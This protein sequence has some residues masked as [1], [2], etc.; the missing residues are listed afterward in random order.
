[1][2]LNHTHNNYIELDRRFKKIDPTKGSEEAALD[3]YTAGFLGHEKT[4][5]WK[6]LLEQ[7]L[8][9]VV[10]EAGSGKTREFQTQT[11]KLNSQGIPAFF[12]PLDR[13]VDES[14]ESILDGQ[15][16]KQFKKWNQGNLEAVFFLDSVDEAK[17]HKITDFL[18][19]LDRFRKS[20]SYRNLQRLK[21]IVSSR[22][23][24]WRPQTDAYELT[25]RFLIHPQS[26]KDSTNSKKSL[27]VVQL[28]PL[29]HTR[30]ELF[31]REYGIANPEVFIQS[32]ED[33]Y[34]WDL[35]RRPMDVVGI[36][37]Y[38]RNHGCFGSLTDIIEFDLSLKLRETDARAKQDPLT[39]QKVREGA[40]TL[41]AAV[42]FCR[43]FNFKV[44]DDAYAT[45]GAA[46]DVAEC[47]PDGW[48]SKE[49]LALLARPIFDSAS[50]G[51]IRFHNRRIQEYLAAQWLTDRMDKGCSITVLEDVLFK[52]IG[53]G[54]VI[55]PALAPITAWL[56][57]G[58]ETWN[59]RVRSWILDAAPWLHSQYADPTFLPL[60]YKRQLL[61]SLIT[62]YEGRQRV[63]VASEP[64]ALR[65]LADP[66]LSDDV[67]RIIRDKTVS[68][69]LRE[70]MLL[71]VR[72]GRLISCR[73]TVLEIIDSPDEPD[74][75]KCYAAAA[76]LDIADQSCRQRLAE[77]VLRLP[78]ISSS[79][80]TIL[81]ETLYPKTIDAIALSSI[82][83]KLEKTHKDNFGL[84]SHFKH[85]LESELNP[86][87]CGDLLK[88][89]II[90]A[91]TPPHILQ[92]NKE[93][94]IS[95]RFCWTSTLILSI[96]I[97]LLS[98]SSLTIS[99][100]NIA[101]ESLLIL[102]YMGDYCDLDLNKNDMAHELDHATQKH[103]TVRQCYFWL[104][105]NKWHNKD[106][107][108]PSLIF[109]YH[110]I[111]KRKPEDLN[112]VIEDIKYR[113]NNTDKEIALRF[114][115]E[116]CNV[117]EK[118]AKNR[119]RVA[120]VV[121]ERHDL[122]KVFCQLAEGDV[123]FYLK[124]VWF[125][126][127]K[128]KLGNGWWWKGKLRKIRWNHGR[129][130]ERLM[131][132]W[133]INLLK[134]G[135]QTHWLAYLA[136]DASEDRS[137]HQWTPVSW[138]GL[139]KSSG[140]LITWGTK[141]G[142]K[143]AWRRFSPQLPH[144][145]SKP[146]EID[147]RIIAGLAGIK[148]ALDDG[149]ID[150]A[151]ISEADARLA[152]RYAVNELN[153]FAPWLTELAIHQ[154]EAVRN[155]L[156]EC[157]RGE[158]VSK[159]ECKWV[160]E[161]LSDLIWQGEGLFHLVK[162]DLIAQLLNGDPENKSILEHALTLLI[163]QTDP[164]III[165]KEIAS[166]RANIY[167]LDSQ[168]F[169]LWLTVWLQTDAKPALQFL[170]ET[171]IQ[172]ADVNADRLI[173][174]V[175]NMLSERTSGRKP[176]L[177]KPD[178]SKPDI[179]RIFI[180]LVYRH[181][182]KS[183]DINRVGGGVYSPNERDDAQDFR[184]SLLDLLVQSEDPQADRVLRELLDEPV[185]NHLKDWICHKLEERAERFSD[186][187]PWEPKDIR[188]FTLEY[189]IDPRT[190]HDLFKIA[191]RRIMDIKYA[192]EKS[193]NSLRNELRREDDESKLRSWI[194]RKLNEQSRKRYTVLQ[195]EEIDQRQR[196]DL[197]I[198]NPR[199]NPIS[200]EIKWADAQWSFSDL[201]ERLENQLIGQ[202]LRAHNSNY[203][204]Y[205]L[206][207]IGNKSYWLHPETNEH[208]SF[209]QILTILEERAKN[210]VSKRDDVNDIYVVGIDFTVP[211][212]KE[213][214]ARENQG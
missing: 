89:L 67:T 85:H 142:C 105:I 153:G 38:W 40:E 10:G 13:L 165:L 23:T 104:M 194:A 168:G 123:K 143:R 189:E 28:E 37:D 36:I 156:A 57:N 76:I 77:I 196:P 144:E 5:G 211:K 72:H 112:W 134:T 7:Q 201:L 129:L 78:Q 103:P 98:K 43:Q 131:L 207:N 202:Y 97:K 213:Q 125:R 170:E 34:L 214:R 51:R 182:R 118:R 130:K 26:N 108:R 107:S 140:R 174:R 133:N 121:A 88:Q 79:L 90:L 137:H 68:I 199:T 154:P 152:T 106:K 84:S 55:R 183:E 9:V 126:Y 119:R 46:I 66:G 175:C 74:D 52:Q 162:D 29:D 93:T 3:S 208:L 4:L 22:I 157:I 160:D 87:D 185:L 19:A 96:L 177:R 30:V 115:V 75:L 171:L 147:N 187:Q 35:A 69:D 161:V 159:R 1:M 122:K 188:L 95:S 179:L 15:E 2:K 11:K 20:F 200:I 62:R 193:D 100:T 203:G 172:R 64:E 192:V 102:G 166:E 70:E 190:D 24:E 191:C 132:I 63:W 6:E 33:N 135:K 56:A 176:L 186:L 128:F 149:E 195:E 114:A 50:Y 184:G 169:I 204:I 8:V 163:R 82:L 44:P 39:M 124:R 113:Q 73:D 25:K 151:T 53:E 209:Q 16:L 58:N 83:L 110:D 59:R 14:L 71:L 99:E 164:P 158:W 48:Q 120:A 141:E 146:S 21:L 109:E 205:L 65:R 61:Q 94:P 138:E 150:F 116:I 212:K 181:I 145:R 197:R 47:L 139:R 101:A 12:V 148:A 173:I 117:F 206:G 91:Q 81:C 178:Y 42:A 54:R 111:L 18:T 41:A 92:D 180:P 31:A 27:L 155:V 45:E 17:F 32:L 86:N 60:E 49:S 198:E 167:S 136:H 127:I 210:I 80:V